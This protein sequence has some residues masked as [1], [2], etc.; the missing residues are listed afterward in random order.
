[1]HDKVRPPFAKYKTARAVF[2]GF[3]ISCTTEYVT[4]VEDLSIQSSKEYA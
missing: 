2:P 4:L 3:N 1:M